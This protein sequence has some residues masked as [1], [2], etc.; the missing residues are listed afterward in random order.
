LIQLLR[1]SYRS[2]NL[3]G[4]ICIRLHKTGEGPGVAA[5]CRNEPSPG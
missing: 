2:S 1:Q 4:T 5:V 3:G